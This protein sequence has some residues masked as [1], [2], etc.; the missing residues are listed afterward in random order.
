M[1]IL[2]QAQIRAF[3]ERGYLV[4]PGLVTSPD[5]ERA[6]AEVDRLIAGAPPPD[7]HVGHHF[8]W[9]GLARPSRRCSL[10]SW[11]DT[12]GSWMPPLSSPGPPVSTSP[13]ARSPATAAICGSG[14]A[15]HH[16]HAAFFAVRGAGAF[17]AAGGHPDVELPEPVQICGRRGDVLLAHYL[18]G[19]NIGGNYE[20]ECTRRALYWRLRI[21][22]HT[23][24]WADCL[25]DPWHE[26]DNIRLLYQA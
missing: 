8:Y 20:S 3:A 9:P 12:E 21:P 26:Y 18:L 23:D 11:R 24:R 22:G 10:N 25:T 6:E 4:L 14:R 19:H 2:A 15:T 17:A 16:L 5:L 7:G 13:S 1:S